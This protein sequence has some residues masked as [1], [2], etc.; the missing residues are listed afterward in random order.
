MSYCKIDIIGITVAVDRSFVVEGGVGAAFVGL[1]TGSWGPGAVGLND[2]VLG[3]R[4]EEPAIDR[5]V[6]SSVCTEG[7]RIANCSRGR[8][9][10]I[11]HLRNA[12]DRIANLGDRLTYEH[13]FPSLYLRQSLH[14]RSIQCCK[15]HHGRS[16]CFQHSEHEAGQ[17]ET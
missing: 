13:R 14:S 7:A 3:L 6:S 5:E 8:I 11:F 15:L 12:A 9:S 1:G 17:T 16:T 4:M 10:T 2:I